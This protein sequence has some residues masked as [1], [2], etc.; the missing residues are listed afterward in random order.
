[1]S[2]TKSPLGVFLIN[3]TTLGGVLD[4]FGYLFLPVGSA[5]SAAV[6]R[7]RVGE[8]GSIQQALARTSSPP[9]LESSS[10]SADYL[11]SHR[12]PQR[13]GTCRYYN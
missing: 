11:A 8:R 1:M 6:M 3:S 2:L 5:A 12:E 9:L 13:A 10:A 7:V 4:K